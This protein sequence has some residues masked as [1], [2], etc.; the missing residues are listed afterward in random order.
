[1]ENI[2]NEKYYDLT[3]YI[4]YLSPRLDN[5]GNQ[6][7]RRKGYKD[8]GFDIYAMEVS[9]L[10]DRLLMYCRQIEDPDPIVN[11]ITEYLSDSKNPLRVPDK[12]TELVKY[13]KKLK[14]KDFP[15]NSSIAYVQMHIGDPFKKDVLRIDFR[16]MAYCDQC[17]FNAPFRKLLKFD[18][19]TKKK[20]QASFNQLHLMYWDDQYMKV[21]SDNQDD[22]LKW[23]T[24]EN[25]RIQVRYSNGRTVFSHGAA[26]YPLEYNT[27]KII[28]QFVQ[29]EILPEQ[30][31]LLANLMLKHQRIFAEKGPTIEDNKYFPIV[32]NIRSFEKMKFAQY[33][34]GVLPDDYEEMDN[35]VKTKDKV[36][37][38]LA[39]DLTD[40]FNRET[41]IT[42]ANLQEKLAKYGLKHREINF[43]AVDVSKM[44]GE[45]VLL[46]IYDVFQV[47]R[48]VENT[49]E[50]LCS[51]G[52]MLNWMYRLLEVG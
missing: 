8:D 36:I 46:I 25:W 9:G 34:I 42:N 44:S 28:Y 41:D 22:L 35:M 37:Y 20:L 3:K 47:D 24:S 29:N 50:I 23:V 38:D 6:I 40:Y 5:D 15:E 31:R 27:L 16:E 4:G 33:D 13:L 45:E 12:D 21:D 26:E 11:E 18:N 17:G 49:Y 19:D 7:L 1:M 51:Q 43:E 30:K 48:F 32:K 14:K 39:G 2:Y 52:Y 10:R